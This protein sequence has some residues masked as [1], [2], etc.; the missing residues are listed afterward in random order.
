M[1]IIIIK[2]K[3]KGNNRKIY[4]FIKNYKNIKIQKIIPR[5]CAV[6]TGAYQPYVHLLGIQAAR[7]ERRKNTGEK[8]KFILVLA[9]TQKTLQAVTE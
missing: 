6:V 5:Y 9:L 8:V 1:S 2:E 4:F 3:V 7:R